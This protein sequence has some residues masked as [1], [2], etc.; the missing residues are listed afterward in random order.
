MIGTKRGSQERERERVSE[1]GDKK[2]A[3]AIW[4]DGRFMARVE[5]MSWIHTN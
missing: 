5:E 2:E 4:K 3:T 1:R